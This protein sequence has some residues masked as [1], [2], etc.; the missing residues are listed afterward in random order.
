MGGILMAAYLTRNDR[1]K[2]Q[3]SP[4][5]RRERRFYMFLSVIAF[6]PGA[7]ALWEIN[8][9]LW[10]MIGSVASGSPDMALTE[11]LRMVPLYLV[12]A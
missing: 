1:I 10:N 9:E 8:Y 2:T 12:G 7:F 3:L 11:A 4:E 6:I 5:A